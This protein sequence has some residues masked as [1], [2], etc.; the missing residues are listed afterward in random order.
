MSEDQRQERLNSLLT[1]RLAEQSRRPR[2]F[3]IIKSLGVGSFG[4]VYVADWHSALPSGAIVPAM[5]HSF[6]R[7][8]YA[9]KRLVAIKKMKKPFV[10]WE[11][12]IQ[13]NELRSLL[14]VPPHDNII[15]LYDVFLSNQSHELHM[16]FECMEGNLYQ[17]V[18]ARKGRPLAQGLVASITKQILEGLHHIHSNNFFHR[19]MKPE[20]LLITTTGLGDY[21]D[22]TTDRSSQTVQQDVLVIVKIA[23]FGLAREITSAPPYTEYVSTRWYRAPEVLLHSPHYTPAVDC[24]ALGTILAEMLRLD[25]LFPGCSEMDQ[26][27]RICY[28]L[29][30]SLRASAHDSSGAVPRGGGSW[31]E[32]NKLCKPFGFR[33]PDIDAEPF[34]PFFPPNTPL[35]LIKMM[36]AMLQYNPANRLTPESCLN[37]AYFR[38]DAP[39]YRLRSKLMP[40]LASTPHRSSSTSDP[41]SPS[42]S[43][44][45]Y[46]PS[47]EF[48]PASSPSRSESAYSPE[49]AAS[50]VNKKSSLYS[51]A[52]H[53]QVAGYPPTPPI[54]ASHDQLREAL[55]FDDQAGSVA[56]ARQQSE[57]RYAGTRAALQASSATASPTPPL[58]FPSGNTSP[59]HSLSARSSP[60]S[61][62]ISSETSEQLHPLS[63]ST[64]PLLPTGK[65][66]DLGH[67]L[68]DPSP[69]NVPSVQQAS[70]SSSSA[71]GG[72]ASWVLRKSASAQRQSKQ[73]KLKKREAE[74]LAM[75]ERSRAVLHKRSQLLASKHGDRINGYD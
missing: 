24:W 28:V 34:A 1:G 73:E 20:N 11:D 40:P 46:L 45:K 3:T 42:Y 19:D 12:C 60:G 36:L 61:K 70:T 29:G 4:T 71:S 69:G 37:H 14:L 48:R 55:G 65:V 59:V 53:L 74:L 25:P 56:G 49:D 68:Q 31:P 23:D 17:L 35:N 62:N 18:R 51:D 75:R 9:N 67:D 39:R 8:E 26:V 33:F 32:I 66:N 16:V 41:W 22:Q 5:Q 44:G 7:P 54:L 2:D 38:E 27:L 58:A 15:P 47:Q 21:Y 57:L 43:D 63:A 30:T 50:F 52:S 10:H 6:T 13:L 72:L 64:S